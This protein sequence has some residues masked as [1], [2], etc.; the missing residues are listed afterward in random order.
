[1]QSTIHKII[2]SSMKNEEA[3]VGKPAVE[4]Y[5]AVRPF[6][7]TIVKLI[8]DIDEKAYIAFAPMTTVDDARGH[9]RNAAID[10]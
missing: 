7:P 6:T 1:M 10:L 9:T 3:S 5:D 4:E 8:F 2:K